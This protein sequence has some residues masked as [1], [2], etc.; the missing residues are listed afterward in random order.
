MFAESFHCQIGVAQGNRKVVIAGMRFTVICTS[1]SLMP[2]LR[3]IVHRR[4]C[5]KTR[6]ASWSIRIG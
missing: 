2:L 3:L 5:S 4:S 6:L 1:V